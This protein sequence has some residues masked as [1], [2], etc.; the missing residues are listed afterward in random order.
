MFLLDKLTKKNV[1]KRLNEVLAQ[2]NIMQKELAKHIGVTDNTVSYY[3]SG[4]RCPDIEKLIEI[5]KFLNVSTDYLLGASNVKTTDTELKSICEYTGLSEAAVNRLHWDKRFYSRNN[6]LISLL[7][8]PDSDIKMINDLLYITG[9]LRRYGD[10]YFELIDKMSSLYDTIKDLP[11][12]EF[13]KEI[14]TVSQEE[15]S[16]NHNYIDILLMFKDLIDDYIN[17]NIKTSA[18]VDVKRKYDEAV[19]NRREELQ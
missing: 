18:N 19:N 1:G 15:K 6:E 3:L 10:E 17:A 16:N 9:A 4:E 14:S 12:E 13:E 5:A 8:A 2:K 7:I 11:I